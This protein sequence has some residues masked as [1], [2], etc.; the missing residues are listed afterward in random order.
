MSPKIVHGLTAKR[1]SLRSG[2]GAASWQR[3]VITAPD[4][5]GMIHMTVEVS[6]PVIP[7]ACPDK[8][9]AVEPFRPVVAI[10]RAIVR[11][12]LVI[13][14]RTNRRPARYSYRYPGWAAG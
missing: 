13:A 4:I 5:E 11:R 10:R 7:R 9:A 14:V 1:N 8:D 12:R 3:S 6:R 2:H